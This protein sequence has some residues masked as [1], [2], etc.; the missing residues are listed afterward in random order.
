MLRVLCGIGWTSVLAVALLFST[1]NASFA[2]GG[3]FG[4]YHNSSRYA[5]N[6]S[7][8]QGSGGGG[9]FG[10]YTAPTYSASPVQSMARSPAEQPAYLTVQLPNADA[11]VLIDGATTMSTGSVRLFE[12]PPLSQGDYTYRITASWMENGRMTTKTREVRVAPGAQ[13]VVNFSQS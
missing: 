9:K 6:A 1:T 12:S 5:T 10:A 7:Y 8:T 3:K 2:Q 13:S 11:S 4:G